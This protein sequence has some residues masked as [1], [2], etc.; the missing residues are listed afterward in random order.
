[1]THDEELKFM[2]VGGFITH[3][4]TLNEIRAKCLEQRAYGIDIEHEVVDR[5]FA[6]LREEMRVAKL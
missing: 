1:M 5:E 6:K 3:S 2:F 4:I